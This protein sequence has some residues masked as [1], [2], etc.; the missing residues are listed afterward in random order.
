VFNK[1]CWEL[2]EANGMDV[3]SGKQAK[4][5]QDQGAWMLQLDDKKRP[6]D[7]EG[8]NGHVIAVT[9][10]HLVDASTGQFNRPAK[11]IQTPPAWVLEIQK[12]GVNR[13]M[14]G[15]EPLTMRRRDG[16]VIIYDVLPH[17]QSFK[18]AS[19]WT[20]PSNHVVARVIIRIMEDVQKDPSLLDDIA[21]HARPYL[22]ESGLALRSRKL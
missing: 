12:A 3:P 5:W 1:L 6:G 9:R 21:K 22:V 18:Q 7:N 14:Q 13:F 17:D 11:Q 20:N 2:V 16:V 4:E 19:G 15:G 8:Y 10:N